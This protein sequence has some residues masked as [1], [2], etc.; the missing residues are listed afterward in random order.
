MF[1]SKD[2]FILAFIVVTLFINSI[3]SEDITVKNEEELINALNQEK[4]SIIKII[5]KIIITEK[6]TVNSSNSKNNK[7]ITVIGDISTKPSIDLTNYII[8]ENCLNVT[9]KDIMLYG[10]LKFNNNRKISIENSVLN[11]TVDATSTNTNS[12]IEINNSNIFCK[13]INNSESCLKI[14]N[15]HTVIHNS[16]IKGNIVP[17][18]RIIGVSGNNRYLNITNSIINGNNYNQ[19]ISIEKGLI[20]IKNSDFINCANYLENG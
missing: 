16:N 15:Y 12:I 4:D 9:I 1:F 2:I 5:G 7:S 10:D 14:L 18:K 3:Y 8:F 11:C 20:N 19:A 17:Y 13:D 6:I